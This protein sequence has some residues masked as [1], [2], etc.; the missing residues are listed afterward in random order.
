MDKNLERIER[1][2]QSVETP[3][4]ASE[5]HRQQW[6]RRILARVEQR[7]TH[8]AR[9]A[10]WRIA[11]TVV[12]L[13]CIGAAIAGVA[14][15]KHFG[16]DRPVNGS[17]ACVHTASTPDTNG[18]AAVQPTVDEAREVD[19]LSQKDSVELVQIIESEVNG[20][21][22]DRTLV[23]KCVLSNR[24]TKAGSRGQ[25]VPAA[26]PAAAWQE[27]G[28][29][30]RAGKGEDLGTQERLMKG[31]VFVFKRERYT[32]HDGTTVILSVGEPKDGQQTRPEPAAEN[33]LQER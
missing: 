27:I 24:Q 18:A 16:A 5:S 22:I 17:P 19:G 7:R 33:N 32:L 12:G 9:H 2:L 6:R 25:Q 3:E 10:A 13:V 14:G 8:P 4:H 28:Q 31:L 21:L 15:R 20:R 29:L 11:A 30:R 23:Q 1:Y 26:L